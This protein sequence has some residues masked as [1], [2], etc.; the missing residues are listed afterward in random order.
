MAITG[1]AITSQVR[2]DNEE[3][4]PYRLIGL[5]NEYRQPARK[6]SSTPITEI[7]T[8]TG[9]A[10]FSSVRASVASVLRQRVTAR[11]PAAATRGY[12]AKVTTYNCRI[13]A[14]SRI[15]TALPEASPLARRNHCPAAALR[16]R[17]PG[18]CYR[19]GRAADL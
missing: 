14:R 2:H 3:L 10:A 1:R 4:E 19:S 8:S 13:M 16:S 9:R 17:P 15:V 11:Q 18:P 7:S 5:I 6:P 12:A